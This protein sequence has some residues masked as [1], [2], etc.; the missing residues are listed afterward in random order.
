MVRRIRRAFTFDLIDVH[1]AYPDDFAAALLP[2]KFKVPVTITFLYESHSES[3][4]FPC[5]E[6]DFHRSLWLD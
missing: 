3:P 4:V 1:F 6:E 5:R 2:K